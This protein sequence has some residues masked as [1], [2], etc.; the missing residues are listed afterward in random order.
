[1]SFNAELEANNVINYVRKY[2]EE[3]HDNDCSRLMYGSAVRR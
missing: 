2:Y 3:N 1:M